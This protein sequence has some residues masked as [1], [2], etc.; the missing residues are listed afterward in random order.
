ARA[1]PRTG[2][3]APGGGLLPPPPAPPRPQ[4]APPSGPPRSS[5]HHP[6][7]LGAEFVVDE[8]ERRGRRRDRVALAAQALARGAERLPQR[9]L[10]AAAHQRRLELRPVIGDPAVRAPA[11]GEPLVGHPRP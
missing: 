9:R 10:A 4:P 5:R 11:D 1:P 8:V 2:G 6:R 3:G 7:A